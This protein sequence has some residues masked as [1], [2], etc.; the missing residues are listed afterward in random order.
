MQNN[1][2]E[3]ATG[4]QVF[5]NK[6]LGVTI[7]TQVINNEPWFVAKD[8]CHALSIA[9]SRDT[10]RKNLDDDERG[11]GIFYTPANGYQGGGRQKLTIVNESGFYNLVFRSTKPEAKKFRK[12]V[13][14][15]V[16]PSIRKTGKYELKTR[17]LLPREKSG[18]MRNFFEQLTHWTTTEDERRIAKMMNVTQKHVHAV[19][20]G[21]TQSYGVACLLV[22]FAKENRVKGVQRQPRAVSREYDMKELML[23]FTEE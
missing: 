9:N 7:R 11:V 13:T 1:S 23:E 19:V 14:S 15:E 22:E 6:E 4:L 2:N 3:Q 16:L 5:N 12:W 18:E 20:C 8:V 10:V 17:R 21:R